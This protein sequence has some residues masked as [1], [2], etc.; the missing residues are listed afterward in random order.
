MNDYYFHNINAVK[1]IGMLNSV[2]VQLKCLSCMIN[3]TEVM[4]VSQLSVLFISLCIYCLDAL[5]HH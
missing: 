5:F 2:W 3:V 4:V 1:G